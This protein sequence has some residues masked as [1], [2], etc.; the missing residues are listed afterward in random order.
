MN[1]KG[2]DM[3][4]ALNGVRDD[5]LM[6]A[7]PPGMGVYGKP[8]KGRRLAGFFDHPW[9]AAAISAAVALV[10]LS[11]IIWAGQQGGKEPGD[12]GSDGVGINGVGNQPEGSVAEQLQRPEGTAPRDEQVHP[13]KTPED[14]APSEGPDY[15]DPILDAKMVISSGN[16]NMAP[17]E[18][19][20]W[21]LTWDDA[22]GKLLETR[23]EMQWTE[24]MLELDS[25]GDD[26]ALRREIESLPRIVY[27]DDFFLTLND[28]NL[29]LQG[30][31][32]YRC[33][34]QGYS[35][36][37]GI[38]LDMGNHSVEDMMRKLGVGSYYVVIMAYDRGDYVE[39]T[40]QN[41]GTMYEFVFR[42]DVE[43]EPQTTDPS[44]KDPYD[45][46]FEPADVKVCVGATNLAVALRPYVVNALQYNAETDAWAEVDGNGLADVLADLHKELPV[47]TYDRNFEIYIKE[48]DGTA[49]ARYLRIYNEYFEEVAAFETPG[50]TFP[51]HPEEIA[52]LDEGI[53]YVVLDMYQ[54]GVTVGEDVERGTYEYG[55]CLLVGSEGQDT[56]ADVAD[57]AAM[58]IGLWVGTGGNY[59]QLK[60]YLIDATVYDD[61]M[62]EWQSKA[63]E[64]LINRLRAGGENLST[65]AYND[66]F[67]MVTRV[68]D[69]SDN[70]D[71]YVIE[72]LSYAVYDANL[73]EVLVAH[74]VTEELDMLSTLSPGTY[75]VIVQAVQAG[76]VINVKGEHL[77]SEKG[78]YHYGFKVFIPSDDEPS[79]ILPGDPLYDDVFLISGNREVRPAGRNEW[80]LDALAANQGILPVASSADCQVVYPDNSYS[81]VNYTVY[82]IDGGVLTR[83]G[84]G[85]ASDL[86]FLTALGQREYIVSFSVQWPDPKEEGSMLMRS[87]AFRL[88]VGYT[89]SEGE[90]GIAIEE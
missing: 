54:T 34:E 38:S 6:D 63:G 81:M 29:K 82:G 59:D 51:W 22:S 44:I 37:Y 42:V 65:V 69:P 1:K 57:M 86:G 15:D 83:I 66:D 13:D 60:P 88:Y 73:G 72:F 16:T 45:D 36:A 47:V 58:G 68:I 19:I 30:A 24:L 2:L 10:V 3:F 75:Y 26:S 5:I 43:N 78:E 25:G 9:V 71:E 49:T 79:D 77:G 70:P 8:I 62:G 80:T 55:F 76:R 50:T 39:A 4:D 85:T 21:Q 41:E 27:K 12:L 46:H 64:K 17:A 74:N 89:W 35:F 40:G 14:Q 28:E 53:W 52:E 18:Y 20:L 87:Y 11:G 31:E 61:E 84:G 23:G 56:P 32:A 67:R 33:D 48:I 90:T 7:V